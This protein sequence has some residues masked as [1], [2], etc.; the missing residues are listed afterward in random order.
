[1]W[2]SDDELGT[3]NLLNDARTLAAVGCVERGRVFP[4]QLPLEEPAPGIVWRSR[5]VHR[6]V[7][8]PDEGCTDRDDYVDGLWLQGS[9]QWD[10]L[11]HMRHPEH[12]N[13]NGVP[14]TD[15]H[16]GRGSR[17]G[18]DKWAARAIVGRAVLVDV[19]RWRSVDL[20]D[21]DEITPDDLDAC[22]DGQGVAVEPGDILLLHTGWMAHVLALPVEER[23]RYLDP[24]QQRVPGLEVADRTLAWLWDSHVAAV[25]ADNVGVEACGPGKRFRLH[26]SLLPLLG[27]PLGEYWWLHDLAADCAADRRYTA[28][29]VSVPLNVRGA[30]GSPAQAIAVK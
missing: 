14:D 15:I 22:L 1:V 4:L 5:P 28:L 25:A 26:Q 8:G 13:Y 9:S 20:D 17:L 2:G 16:G 18:V 7:R 10:G 21:A 11:T 6:I 23:G 27:L 3:L 24:E 12:G 29:L 30:V 19:A